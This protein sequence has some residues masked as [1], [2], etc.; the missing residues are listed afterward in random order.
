[1]TPA[2][3]NY[4]PALPPIDMEDNYEQNTVEFPIC[5]SILERTWPFAE[6]NNTLP[7]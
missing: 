2:T 6:P 5:P 1:M 4:I 7:H 3:P